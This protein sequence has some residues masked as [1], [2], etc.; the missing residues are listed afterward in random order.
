MCQCKKETRLIKPEVIEEALAKVTLRDEGA[1]PA[2][3]SIDEDD[4][5]FA[6]GII[7]DCES[8]NL[9]W[10]VNAFG[11]IVFRRAPVSRINADGRCDV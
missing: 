2:E 3:I 6:P 11:D 1:P 7:A 5:V 4:G 10:P 9:E 8:R